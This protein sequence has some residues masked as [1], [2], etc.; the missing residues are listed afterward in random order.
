M[1]EEK[2]NNLVET[3][4]PKTETG[5][6]CYETLTTA[7]TA[8]ALQTDLEKGLT[9]EEAK[10]RLEKYGPNKL[11]EKKK[12][13]WFRIFIEQMNNPM[14]FVLFAAIIVTLGISIFETINAASAGWIVDGEPVVNAFL[15]VG[16]WPD[17]II[18]L[19]VI[20][21]N[22]VIGTVQEIKA[23]NSLEA[24]KKLSSPEST[25]IRDGVR[26]KIKSSDLVIG[27]IV[28]LEEGDT[29]GADLRLIE[30][31]NL[32]ANESS[33][34]GESVPIEKDSEIVFSEKVGIGDRINMVYM[35]TPVTYGRGKG[36]VTSTGMK[37]EIGKIANALDSEEE[38]ETPLQKSLAKLSKF[39]GML[40]LAIVVVVLIADIIWIFVDG[41]GGHLESWLDAIISSIALAVAAIPEGLPAVVTIVL[42]IGVQR[43]VKANTVVRKLPSVET[44]GSVSVVCSDKTGTLTQNKMTVVEAYVNHNYHTQDEFVEESTNKTLKLLARGMSLC[45]NA[46]VDEGLYGDPTEIALVA[47]ANEFNMHKKDMET[48]T[49]RFN[50]LPFDSVRKMMSTQHKDSEGQI[51]TYTKGALDSI[52]AH[53]TKIYVDGKVR[54]IKEE[55]V[56][57]IYDANKFFS[58]KA[59]RVLA[60]AY[61]NLNELKEEELVFVGLVAMIDPA[62]PEAKPAVAQF[63]K[64]GITTVMITGDH[65]DTAFAIA[66]ELGIAEDPSQCVMGKEIDNLSPDE[67]QELCKNVRVF[68]RVS[69][70]NKVA[71][72]KAFKANGNICAMTGDGVNDAPSLKAADIG[73]AMGI[74]GTD[75]AKGAADMVLT[76]DNFA[77]IEKAVEEGRGI[78]ANIKK[79]VVFLLS[80]NI[81]EVLG[82]FFIICIGFPTPF[83]AIHLLWVNLI[84]DSLPAIALGMDPKDPKNMEEKPRDPKEGILSNGGLRNT[85]LFGAIITVAVLISYFVAALVSPEFYSGGFADLGFTGI[86]DFYMT[87][88]DQLHEAQTMAFTTLAVSELFHMIGMSDMNRSFIYVFAKK[89]WMMLVAFIAG[90]ALQLFV[91]CVPG[92][93]QVFSTTNLTLSEWLIT[94][95]L[96]VLPLIAH[97]I[98]VFINWLIKRSNSKKEVVE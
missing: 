60:L 9:S 88:P 73:I 27:D 5:G 62:R 78:Y 14:I 86:K 37:T 4:N 47:F 69:P 77:S 33:L 46:T 64:A 79:T 49:P 61:N 94:C 85:V 38:E 50:E 32:K 39:L 16:D 87:H 18:I 28:V 19:A 42:A 97:E 89:N 25:V 3:E 71:I 96:A 74:T 57:K 15:D 63:K 66:K 6:I 45:S 43:M 20:L 52:L 10:A 55:D 2:E 84:T 53:T 7:Q 65:K 80:S 1:A 34:T 81:A 75:V 26:M 92:V 93:Q 13:G 40:T 76:D 72:V 21:L 22:A 24:L 41:N 11:E 56:A 82:M 36:I 23:Q 68:A 48:E 44:L 29:I 98:Y 83:I 90:L 54:D 31:V 12:K 30:A 95:A 58:D 35:S 17:V 59:L 67:L 91:I 51:I 8:E 70:E